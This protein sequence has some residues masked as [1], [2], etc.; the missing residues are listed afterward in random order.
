MVLKGA[1][2][3]VKIDTETRGS[4]NSAMATEGI[5]G[6]ISQSTT[7]LSSERTSER[8]YGKILRSNHYSLLHHLYSILRWSFESSSAED[9][10]PKQ[11]LN[12]EGNN[13]NIRL[14]DQSKKKETGHK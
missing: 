11:K 2:S 9:L 6:T 13:N 14:T 8:K 10:A 4:M 7:D 12:D 5:L 3:D 1:I